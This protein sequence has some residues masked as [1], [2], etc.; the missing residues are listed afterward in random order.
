[1]NK[2]CGVKI[3]HLT[4]GNMQ[5][6]ILAAGNSS[7]VYP[8]SATR[9][10]P[11]L[12]VANKTTIEHNLEQLRGL[13]REVIIVIGYK[14]KM[15]RQYLGRDFKGVKL[16]YIEQKH[17][18]G[19]AHALLEAKNRIKGKFLVLYGDDLY[20]QKDIKKCLKHRC[21]FLVQRIQDPS[22][23][24]VVKIEGKVIKEIVEKPKKF[25]S[26]LVNVGVYVFDDK[27]FKVLKNLGKSQRGEYELTDGVNILAGQTKIYYEKANYW[28][29]ISYPWNLLEANAFLLNQLKKKTI[30][31]KV[32]QGAI[33]KGKV[34]IDRGTI[35]K[36]GTYI[37]GPVIIGKNCI[38]GPNCFLRG[39]TAIDDN[40]HIGQ[41]AEIKNS[42]IGK[43]VNIA[44]FSYIGDSIL[45]EGVNFGA[46]ATTANLRQD[47]KNIKSM[48][49]G[50][51]IDSGLKE[52]G[53]IIGDN[54]KIGVNTFFYPGIKMAPFTRTLPGEVVRKDVESV[55]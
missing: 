7:R 24:G 54:C 15:I 30:K 11:L 35:I 48:V 20:N 27:I 52:L 16:S 28:H 42:I 49:K 53:V 13:A 21:S 6:V 39:A 1:M 45:G 3:L 50:K 46:G 47:G 40:C 26:D 2:K 36:S 22:Q 10:K 4:K 17:R 12:K 8:L 29:P 14:E 23:F 51:L 33:I 9:P 32:E 41:A 43:A 5:A 19:T 34:I 25:I 44:Q 31:G 18:L 37:E 38:I 55:D